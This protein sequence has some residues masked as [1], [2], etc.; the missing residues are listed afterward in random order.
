MKA[1]RTREPPMLR[2]V[3][4]APEE[5]VDFVGID[6]TGTQVRPRQVG[7]SNGQRLLSLKPGNRSK[8]E[9]GHA[10]E[11]RHGE[12]YANAEQWPELGRR[13]GCCHVVPSQLLR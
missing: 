3:G 8:C 2:L 1:L 13:F 4:I 6:E 12:H 7:K 11:N 5:R 10:E 9:Q